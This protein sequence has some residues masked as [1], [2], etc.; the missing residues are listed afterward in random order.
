MQI[1]ICRFDLSARELL[2][3]PSGDFVLAGGDSST[4]FISL[5]NGQSVT[6]SNILWTGGM[7]IAQS[8]AFRELLA[9]MNAGFWVSPHCLRHIN[10]NLLN[11]K[12][13]SLDIF[14]GIYP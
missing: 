9:G 5:P 12:K 3:F 4:Q 6:Q 8:L 2:K 7:K 10:L 11:L 1:L 14:P 13:F